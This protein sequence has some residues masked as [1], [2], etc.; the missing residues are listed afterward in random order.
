MNAYWVWWIAAA[1]LVGAELLSNTFYL[2]AVG[3]AAALGGLAALLNAP[4]PWQFVIAGIAGVG[5][6]AM[7]HQWR[8]RRAQPSPLPSFDVG[9]SV[10]V[11]HWNPD[12][13]ARVAYRGSLWDAELAGQDVPRA[14]TLYIVATRGSMLVL[15]DRRPAA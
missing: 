1:V 12:G 13:T 15:S 14:D 10:R 11:E 6:T 2:L 5:L 7:A 3:I 9:Q 8:R 4:L